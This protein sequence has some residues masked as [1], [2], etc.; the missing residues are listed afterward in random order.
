MFSDYVWKTDLDFIISSSDRLVVLSFMTPSSSADTNVS[1][2]PT[3]TTPM[4][5]QSMMLTSNDYDSFYGN[6]SINFHHLMFA[7]LWIIRYSMKELE[8]LQI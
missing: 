2:T 3:P 6:V 4:S 7:G 1:R 5:P 8:S